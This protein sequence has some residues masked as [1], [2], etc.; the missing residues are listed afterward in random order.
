MLHQESS[1]GIIELYTLESAEQGLGRS[2]SLAGSTVVALKFTNPM[3]LRST[4]N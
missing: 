1:D 2:I 3:L 4:I